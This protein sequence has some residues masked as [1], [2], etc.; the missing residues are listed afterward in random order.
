MDIN[1]R[2]SQVV[3]KSGLSKTAFAE[4][5][6][7]SQQHVSRLC[8]DGTPSDRT[9]AD[10]CREFGVNEKWLRDGDGE[11]FVEISRDEEIAAFMSEIMK[12]DDADFRRRL[13][14]VLCRLDSDEWRLLEQVANKLV[15]EAKKAGPE[16][17]A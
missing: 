16:G 13:I 14:S 2:I 6:N 10:I 5:I 15:E 3:A 7:V 11:M 9:I 1:E 17:P 12:D 8:K 4:R